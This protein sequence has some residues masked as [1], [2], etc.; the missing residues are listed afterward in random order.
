V[1][2]TFSAIK[3]GGKVG[4][5]IVGISNSTFIYECNLDQHKNHRLW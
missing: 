3:L 2:N 5:P 4:G 1:E